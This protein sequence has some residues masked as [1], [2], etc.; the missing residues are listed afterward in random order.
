M[1]RG[2]RSRPSPA[3]APSSVTIRAVVLLAALAPLARADAVTPVDEVTN[4]VAVR[5]TASSQSTQVGA[6]KRGEIAE[7]LGSVPYWHRIQ[8]AN[9]VSGFVSKRWTRVVG[10]AP[11]PAGVPGFTMDVVDVGTGLAVLV[12]GP[13]FTLV[14]DGGSNDDLAKGAAN[15]FLSHIRAVAPSLASIDHMVLSHP[16]R[17]HVEL[18]PDLFGAF[19]VRHVWDSGRFHTIC[20]YRLFLTAIRDEPGVQYHNALQSFGSRTY[21]FSEAACG[22]PVEDVTI[23]LASRI[24]DAPIP[25][26]ANASMSILHADGAM[27]S[28]PNENSMV[29]LLHLGATR[30]LLMGD[31]E[32]GGRQDPKNAP[33]PNSIEGHLLACCSGDLAAHV[34]VVGHH[35]SMT[36]SRRTLL[37]AVGASIFV[38][39]SG[40]MKYGAVTL[41]DKVVIDELASRG[42]VFRTDESDAACAGNPSKIGPDSDGEAGGCDTIRVVIS[43]AKPPQASVWRGVD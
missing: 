20:G 25:L 15:R 36:S 32:A 13:D 12:R 14:Y 23:A 42:A 39:S 31:A 29:V 10:T 37:D 8:L 2:R 28:S 26:G 43:D 27:H 4:A 7:L 16:H 38:V 22:R 30:V 24:G 40:P 11:P 19:Q 33:S 6:L 1:S 3:P 5:N 18:L 9:G 17:D 21:K 41:P 34:M 35:G